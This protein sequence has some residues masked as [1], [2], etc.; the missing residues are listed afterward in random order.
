MSLEIRLPST[1]SKR[2]DSDK[3]AVDRTE[4]ANL[5]RAHAQ[6]HPQARQVPTG[7]VDWARRRVG[8]AAWH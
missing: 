4:H 8:P 6:L 2:P 1:P 3:P 5:E 7:E